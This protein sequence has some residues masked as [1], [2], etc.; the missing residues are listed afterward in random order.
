MPFIISF[1][2]VNISCF[3]HVFFLSYLTYPPPELSIHLFLY[4]WNKRSLCRVSEWRLCETTKPIK[5]QTNNDSTSKGQLDLWY[6]LYHTD[7]LIDCFPI[8]FLKNYEDMPVDCCAFMLGM[9]I[10]IL[11]Q[12]SWDDWIHFS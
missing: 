10:P 12:S 11:K 2:Y 1:W 7:Y 9:T 6:K 4:T 3:N 8:I 5:L